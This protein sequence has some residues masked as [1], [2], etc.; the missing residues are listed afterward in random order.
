MNL[1]I[2]SYVHYD[3]N[4]Q[5]LHILIRLHNFLFILQNN[6]FLYNL[7]DRPENHKN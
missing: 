3:I 4:I 2:L 5:L 1:N 6:F 7:I